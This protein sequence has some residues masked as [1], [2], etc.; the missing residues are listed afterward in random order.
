MGKSNLLSFHLMIKVLI[1]LKIILLFFI[2]ILTFMP[3]K[4]NGQEHN[5]IQST[6]ILDAD[7]SI[8]L[9]YFDTSSIIN[10]NIDSIILSLYVLDKIPDTAD[11]IQITI[12][13]VDLNT[14]VVEDGLSTFVNVSRDSYID[15]KLPKELFEKTIRT[16]KRF[17]VRLIS[18]G[19]KLVLQ[20]P[21]VAG[22][23]QDP[24][25]IIV[26]HNY[27]NDTKT[28]N[29]PLVKEHNYYNI[30]NAQ[31]H[32]GEGNNVG[33]DKIE[34]VGSIGNDIQLW[35]KYIVAVATIL[36]VAWGIYTFFHKF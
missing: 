20:G 9:P 32:F 6:L 35:L 24:K 17:L 18:G 21:D 3:M 31:F 11:K 5:E 25:L 26:E 2:S 28:P 33:R 10:S 12:N 4:I 22:T 36:G 27:I 19:Q 16:Q 23:S 34:E 30:Q 15:F 13:T 14:K 8:V 29:Q 7:T 1:K